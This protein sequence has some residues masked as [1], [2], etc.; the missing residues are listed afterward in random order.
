MV[1]GKE[2]G[3]SHAAAYEGLA[4]CCAARLFWNIP[5]LGVTPILTGAFYRTAFF[6]ANK[7][8]GKT[9]PPLLFFFFFFFFLRRHI[10]S[11]PPKPGC[12]TK[13]GSG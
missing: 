9:L 2:V 7:W 10:F 3:M 6:A 12:F 5:I 13:T 8:C 11:L 4:M 1:L